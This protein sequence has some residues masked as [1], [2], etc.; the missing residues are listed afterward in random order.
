MRLLSPVIARM[1]FRIAGTLVVDRK[2]VV[3]ARFFEEVYQERNTASSVLTRLGV[4]TPGATV[5]GRTAH[6]ALDA[7]I[8]DAIVA[9]G[10]QI[11]ITLDIQPNRGV[12]VYAPGKH[13]YQVVRL[14]VD[15]EPWLR[16]HP[17]LYPQSGCPFQ[18]NG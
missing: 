2:G 5:S 11:T 15:P 6:L 18:A 16:V 3:T 1:A 4:G 17:S 13:T 14:V 8:S 9:P 12:H 10:E 7:S